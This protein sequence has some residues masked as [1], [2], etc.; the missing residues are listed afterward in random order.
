[1][2][3]KQFGVIPLIKEDG[4]VRVVLVT[5]RT[6][7]NWIFPKG[8]LID[9]QSAQ[10]SALQEAYEEAGIRGR[11]KGRMK[12]TAL[13]ERPDRNI[14]LTLFPMRVVKLLR[15][16]PEDGERRRIVVSLTEAETLLGYPA[17]RRCLREWMRAR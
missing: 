14:D 11:I 2:A 12:F 15:T 8:G 10:D 1:M 17:M 3:D 5:S 16:W 9:G 6:N 4:K 13:L 7:R